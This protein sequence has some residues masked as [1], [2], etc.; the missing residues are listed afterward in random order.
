MLLSII[1]PIYNVEKY[2][3]ECLNSVAF[4]I[5]NHVELILIN[6]G[7]TD[8]SYELAKRFIK[9]NPLVNVKLIDKINGGL[10][11]ARNVG[12]RN[13]N[14]EYVIFLDG[15][16]TLS[17][18]ALEIIKQNIAYYPKSDV[19]HYSL[20]RV[21]SN[22]EILGSVC[23]FSV[24][25]N[26][27]YNGINAYKSGYSPSSVCCFVF[28]RNFLIDNNLFFI[29]GFFHEDVE[30]SSRLLTVVNEII[31]FDCPWYNY[32]IRENS[33]TTS[34]ESKE[35]YLYDNLVVVDK[36][37]KYS[38]NV[39]FECY[40]MINTISNTII[41]NFVIEVF[42]SSA[43]DKENK[44]HLLGFLLTDGYL[45]LHGQFKTIKQKISSYFICNRYFIKI[46]MRL[47]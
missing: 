2:L 23:D 40:E 31:F 7:S 32:F 30:F 47:L 4:Q 36:L 8:K 39:D 34:I 19:H 13:C 38:N 26:K 25:K 12:L 22:N 17:E 37:S 44:K 5:D 45:P 16:D 18:N 28:R 46:I 24:L 6:D 20:N 15:D 21:N 35:K 33:Q 9:G 27:L 10:S 3:L 29:D 43:L 11:D 41:W 1:I 42:F 14:Y